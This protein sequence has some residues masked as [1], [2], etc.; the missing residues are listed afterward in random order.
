MFKK[1]KEKKPLLLLQIN[2]SPFSEHSKSVFIIHVAGKKTNKQQNKKQKTR[3]KKHETLMAWKSL[4]PLI[5]LQ[6]YVGSAWFLRSQTSF[7]PGKYLKNLMRKNT[8]YTSVGMGSAAPL[9]AV[10]L[11]G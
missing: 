1:K 2:I 9:S 10:A 6:H 4:N 3:R 5:P 8:L 11:T 7:M